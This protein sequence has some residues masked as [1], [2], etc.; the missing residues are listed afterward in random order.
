MIR[1]EISQSRK[2][3]SCSRHMYTGEVPLS[4]NSIYKL[5]NLRQAIYVKQ[6]TSAADLHDI[7]LGAVFSSLL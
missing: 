7:N 1:C 6:L 2:D 5:R 3:S 4:E